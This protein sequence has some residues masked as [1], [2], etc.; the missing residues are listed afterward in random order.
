MQSILNKID[1][2]E[3][4]IQLENIDVICIT[5]HCLQHSDIDNL[6][7]QDFHP[8]SHFSR[9]NHKRGGSVIYTKANLNNVKELTKIKN[10]N[11]MLY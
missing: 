3:L 5:E 6:S 11:R 2:I 1:D 7:I 10:R 8:S 4:F 9:K